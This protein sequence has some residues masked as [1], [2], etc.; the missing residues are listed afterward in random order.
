MPMKVQQVQ[1]DL[2]NS[3]W[4]LTEEQRMWILCIMPAILPPLG[5]TDRLDI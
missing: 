1:K 4:M 5:K 3:H 2:R